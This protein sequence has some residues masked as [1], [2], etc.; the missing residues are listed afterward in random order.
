MSR[1][2]KENCN[3]ATAA[4]NKSIVNSWKTTKRRKMN[5]NE[6]KRHIHYSAHFIIPISL[7]I[8][9]LRC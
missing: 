3:I 8:Q 5:S 2:L 7:P 9:T 1:L 4:L 6:A